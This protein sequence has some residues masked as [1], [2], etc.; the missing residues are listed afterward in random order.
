[1]D[2]RASL[3]DMG[4]RGAKPRKPRHSQH[5]PKVGTA[6]ENERAL[7]E[8]REAVLDN[9]GLAGVGYWTKVVIVA[10]AVLILV[11][12]VVALVALD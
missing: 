1:M 12:A 9:V 10:I 4:S 8:E 6:T 11:G 7:H 5:L 3:T 2:F